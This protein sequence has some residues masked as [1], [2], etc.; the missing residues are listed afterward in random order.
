MRVILLQI[1]SV[2]LF[3]IA[4]V[5]FFG[6]AV[7]LGK[8]PSHLE[9]GLREISMIGAGILLTLILHELT[10][11]LG[12]QMLG[13]KPRYG[14]LWKQMMF[15]AS[16]PGFAY[17]RNN[18]LQIALAPLFVL[19]ILAVVGI[20][21]LRGTSWVAI[22]GLCGVLNVSGAIGDIWMTMI[23]LRYSAKAYVMDERDGI[24]V[25]LPEP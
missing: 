10:H 20:W 13:A 21:V 3:I 1:F 7:N 15:Y 16:S 24:R 6:L 25:F 23:V 2:P 4:Y 19:S 11:G 12:M 14:I 22:L 5:I 18:Y 8:M 9:L 17:R